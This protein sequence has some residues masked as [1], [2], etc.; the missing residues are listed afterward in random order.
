LKVALNR[1]PFFFIPPC[2]IANVRRSSEFI[3]PKP[4]S[5]DLQ[6]DFINLIMP[7]AYTIKDQQA[8][9]FVTF[10]VHQWVDVF[11]R[12]IYVDELLNSISFCQKNKGLKVYAWVVMSN[13]CHFIL[14]TDGRLRLSDVIRDFKKF[15][16][17]V[18]YKAIQDNP[19][20]SRKKW[21][22]MTLNHEGRVWFWEEGYHG[23]EIFSLKFFESKLNYIHL[24]PVRAGIVEKEEEYLNSSAGEIYGI[25]KGILELSRFG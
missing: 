23:E 25:R 7:F 20:E 3:I 9:H 6:S 13:H 18:I 10:T 12:Q 15:T 21:L 8:L 24:N 14:S 19:M 1:Q 4:L 16:S 2:K 11:T 17:K 22:L 5:Q